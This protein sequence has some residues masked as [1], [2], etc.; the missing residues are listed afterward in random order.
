MD[1]FAAFAPARCPADA[2][3]SPLDRGRCRSPRRSGSP[4]PADDA[5]CRGSR[6]PCRRVRQDALVLDPADEG[7]RAVG[8]DRGHHGRDDAMA[9]AHPPHDDPGRLRR[10][11]SNGGGAGRRGLDVERDARSGVHHGVDRIGEAQPPVL[12]RDGRRRVRGR[13]RL[14]LV[15]PQTFGVRDGLVAFGEVLAPSR[16]NS[17]A[18]R[19]NWPRAA[20]A[21]ICVPSTTTCSTSASPNARHRSTTRSN[22][23]RISLQSRKRP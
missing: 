5:A 12:G 20:L 2:R 6:F 1:P 11:K 9:G 8:R 23:V 16:S 3:S 4:P 13:D 18:V 19:T 21:P 15:A 22:M 17:S 7:R 10:F 14:G